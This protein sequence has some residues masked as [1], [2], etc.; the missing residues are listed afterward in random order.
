WIDN[1][2]AFYGRRPARLRVRLAHSWPTIDR[3]DLTL[4]SGFLFLEA[5]MF[6]AKSN[7]TGHLFR[8]HKDMTADGVMLWVGFLNINDDMIAASAS[9]S[10]VN[11][12]PD[13]FDIALGTRR[14]ESR[15]FG[16]LRAHCS[17]EPVSGF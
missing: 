1:F 7:V 3:V 10:I 16:L 5:T 4:P 11:D 15:W 6:N 2:I 17:D 8:I 9:L 12:R 13:G 14:S